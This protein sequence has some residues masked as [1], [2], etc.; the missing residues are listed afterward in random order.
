L[1]HFGTVENAWIASHPELRVAGLSDAVANR[2]VE[3]RKNIHPPQELEMMQ[4]ARVTCALYSSPQYPTSLGQLYDAPFIL[5]VRGRLPENWSRALAVVGTRKLTAYGMQITAPIIADLIRFE[6]II[7]SGLAIGIDAL[8]HT[9]ALDAGGVTIAVLGG[10]VDRATV[11]PRQNYLLAESIVTHGGALISEYP[12]HAR[13]NKSSFP[14]R[15]RIIA[16]LSRGV[17]VIEAPQASGSLITAKIA[18]DENREVFAVPGSITNPSARGSNSLIQRGAHVALSGSDVAEV[19][20][21]SEGASRGREV[22]GPALTDTEQM[23]YS[24]VT[25]DPLHADE[26]ARTAKL[27]I[28]ETL[29]TLVLME[30]KGCIAQ[31][32][33]LQYVRS[34]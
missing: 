7:V 19:L 20:Q 10:G 1:R 27:D 18:L 17:L 2:F 8:A 14:Q 21:F 32:G 15:N 30:L 5:Y 29:R 12:V 31:V 9:A 22:S 6:S 34:W 26:L 24:L 23:L 4:R 3:E 16:G 28:G 11:G 13:P 33:P 25:A